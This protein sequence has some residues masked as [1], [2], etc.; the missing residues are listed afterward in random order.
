MTTETLREKDEGNDEECPICL[1]PKILVF[2]KC[3]HASCLECFE[4]ILLA[5]SLSPGNVA[6]ND[7][8]NDGDEALE[9]RIIMTCP[10]RGRCPF[11][12]SYVNMFDLKYC[13][14]QPDPQ[15]LV[16]DKNTNLKDSPL[17]GLEFSDGASASITSTTFSFK[18]RIPEV[19][20]H[21][22]ES[23]SKNLVRS[24]PFDGGYYYHP[25][26]MILSGIINWPKVRR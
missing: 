4:R 11:C 1:L 21:S 13:D 22:D 19:L 18:E 26:S 8:D 15:N 24:Q 6:L 20:L 23:G 14:G 5:T 9:E 2:T 10:T 25:K 16:Y 3:S 17:N 12:R 7:G